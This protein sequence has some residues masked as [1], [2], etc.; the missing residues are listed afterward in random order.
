MHEAIPQRTIVHVPHASLVVPPDVLASFVV[1]PDVLASELL[2]MTDRYTDE[3]FRLPSEV[4]T[5]IEFPVSRLVVDPERFVDDSQEPMSAKG[6]GA[7]YTRTSDGQALRRESFTSQQ[8]AEL[9]D[10]YYH[11]HHN[12]LS[13]AVAKAIE[14]YGSCLLIDG[15]SFGDHPYPHEYDQNPNRP[16]ICIGTDSFHTP[17]WLIDL[18]VAVFQKPGWTVEVDRPFAGTIVPQPFFQQNREV[19]SVMVEINRSRYMDEAT[20]QKRDDFPECAASTQNALLELIAQAS[21]EKAASCS[22]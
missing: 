9:L 2:R 12:L 5:A 17:T 18:A 11:P 19:L 4:A 21:T 8:R 20:G 1:S 13:S 22:P 10:T 15:H 14:M 7:V 6:M 16:D 3:L